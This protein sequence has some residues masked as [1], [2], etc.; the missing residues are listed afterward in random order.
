MSEKLKILI[1]DDNEKLRNNL[2]DILQLKGY[3][4][5]EVG[6]GYQAIELVKNNGF[7]VVLL[8]IKMPG[9]DG[10]DTLKTLRGIVPDIMV[11]MV[12]AFADDA[13]Y[14][15]KLR[16]VNFEIIQKP[17]NMNKLWALLE[18]ANN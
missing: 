5:V 16:N 8:D 12:T 3:E 10:V 6:D 14:K 4:V 7:D 2:F 9:I 13:F 11:I 15:E 18:K 17:I 1:V